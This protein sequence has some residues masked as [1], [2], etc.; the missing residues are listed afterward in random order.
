MIRIGQRELEVPMWM[1]AAV[2]F[3]FIALAVHE[4]TKYGGIGTEPDVYYLRIVTQ[5]AVASVAGFLL[6]DLM[7]RARTPWYGLPFLLMASFAASTIAI[8]WLNGAMREL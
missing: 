4:S 2:P 7:R 8:G 3:A 5:C 1:W 6:M